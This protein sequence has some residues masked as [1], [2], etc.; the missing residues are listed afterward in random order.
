MTRSRRL[1]LALVIDLVLV[2][3]EAVGGLFAHSSGLSATAATTSPTPPRSALALVATRL[4]L[5][6]ATAARSFGY[7]R[8]T[9]LAALVNATAIVVVALGVVVLA[10]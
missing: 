8:A 6:P 9:I 1:V 5:K 4:A 7:H 10:C 3:V 2:L